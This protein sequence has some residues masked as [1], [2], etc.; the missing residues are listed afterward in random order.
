[1]CDADRDSCVRIPDSSSASMQL[2]FRM[3]LTKIPNPDTFI[4]AFTG[5]WLKCQEGLQTATSCGRNVSTPD[6]ATGEFQ[7]RW[8]LCTFVEEV[9]DG[10]LVRCHV[11]CMRADCASVNLLVRLHGSGSTRNLCDIGLR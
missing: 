9:M 1:M 8:D 6:V 5:T 4:L 11:E 2:M 7:G 10:P 3:T